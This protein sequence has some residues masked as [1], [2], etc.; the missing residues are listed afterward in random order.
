MTSLTWKPND[1]QLIGSSLRGKIGA[2]FDRLVEV[3]GEPNLLNG[4]P[5]GDPFAV[6]W[7]TDDYG[8]PADHRAAD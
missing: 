3:F 6:T 4:E 7:I 5:S 2:N 8:E 1:G